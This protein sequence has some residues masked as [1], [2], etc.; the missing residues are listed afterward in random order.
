MRHKIRAAIIEA[1]TRRFRNIRLYDSVSAASHN[2]FF[3]VRN[4]GRLKSPAGRDILV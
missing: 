1:T 2:E 4:D 3:P